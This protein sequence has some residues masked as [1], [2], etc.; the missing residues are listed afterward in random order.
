MAT[1]GCFYRRLSVFFPPVVSGTFVLLIGLLLLPVGFSYVG[2]G[3]GAADFGAPPIC[4]WQ[5]WCSGSPSPSIS[6]GAAFSP[7]RR[8]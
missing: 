3:F 6:S 7:R 5:R 4:C 2:G 1:V 8:C